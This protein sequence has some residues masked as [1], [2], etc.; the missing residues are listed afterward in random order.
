MR[1]RASLF[2]A[3]ALCAGAPLNGMADALADLVTDRGWI[4]Y[5]PRNYNP[6][7]NQQPSEASMRA[8]LQQLYNAGWRHVYNYTLD[9]T[10]SEF[11]RIAKEV[12]FENVFAGIFYFDAGQLTRE[13]AAAQAEDQYIDGYLVGNEGLAF[14]RYSGN[15]LIDAITFFEGFGKPLATT[16]VGGLYLIPE[17]DALN[18]LGDFTT[19]NIQPWFNAS[20]NPNDPVAMARAVRD[21]YVAIKALRPDR[22]VV[23]KEAW[24]P[25]E[26]LPYSN[27]TPPPGAASEANQVAFYQAL[28]NETDAAGDPVLFMWGESHDQP[29]KNNEQS[30]FGLIGPD[31][32]FYESNGASKQLVG[33]LSG[34]YTGQTPVNFLPG[35]FD[36]DGVVDP[37]DYS[38]W[39]ASYGSPREIAGTAADGNFDRTIDAADY[40]VWRD[41]LAAP[42]TSAIPESGSAATLLVASAAAYLRRFRFF[43]ASSLHT[44]RA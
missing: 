25:T 9:G 5:S 18:D 23:I 6:N 33:D 31:W 36:R 1:F 35:D 43:A 40:T 7:I 11:P 21:E 30:P 13:K 4:G 15:D 27:V 8:D 34:V 14:E 12:G 39:Q 37:S 41:A 19:V 2:I 3:A 42:A 29:W 24:W 38:E 22:L 10:Q 44:R 28:A 16:E 20:L 26:A 32:G 17:A